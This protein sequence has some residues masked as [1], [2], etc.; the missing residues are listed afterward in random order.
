[1]IRFQ[2]EEEKVI[3]TLEY[4]LFEDNT[5][6]I[7]SKCPVEIK[8]C[9][10]EN[11]QFMAGNDKF[12]IYVTSTR[13]ENLLKHFSKQLIE[14]YLSCNSIEKIRCSVPESIR[15]VYRREFQKVED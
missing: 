1:M 3:E 15:L 14:D 12:R 13:R 5:C 8:I 6:R 7:E 4:S 9:L 2:I 10:L 11:G